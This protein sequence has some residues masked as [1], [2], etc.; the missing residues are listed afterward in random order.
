MAI[1]N[2]QIRNKKTNLDIRHISIIYY[3]CLED[4]I[5]RMLPMH[6]FLLEKQCDGNVSEISLIIFSFVVEISYSTSCY[7]SNWFDGTSW[8]ILN[9]KPLAVL[10]SLD[11]SYKNL[12]HSKPDLYFLSL[13][14][15][16]AISMLEFVY[17]P[18]NE[19]NLQKP[20]TSYTLWFM[21]SKFWLPMRSC[22]TWPHRQ[23]RMPLCTQHSTTCGFLLT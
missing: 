10:W 20:S 13:H 14:A 2:S 8:W 23:S 15:N 21:S 3:I 1:F 5:E 22:H 7:K 9:A 17:F 12:V 16:I 6:M 4:V 11:P 18:S 19:K